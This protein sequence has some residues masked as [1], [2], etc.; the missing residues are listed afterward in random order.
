LPA[1]QDENHIRAVLSNATYSEPLSFQSL[2][3]R[4]CEGQPPRV[5]VTATCRTHPKDQAR[6]EQIA[7]RLS[8]EKGASSVSWSAKE[9][10]PHPSDV[11]IGSVLIPSSERNQTYVTRAESRTLRIVT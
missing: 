11:G 5:E 1:T 2:T 6:L 10:S 9:R 3:S 4:D 8:M 7:S